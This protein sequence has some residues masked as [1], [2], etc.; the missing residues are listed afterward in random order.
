M[1]VRAKPLTIAQRRLR[2]TQLDRRLSKFA[3]APSPPQQGWVRAIRTALR[4]TS[5]QLAGRLQITQQSV[6]AL[7]Q[8]ESE[9]NITLN[10]LRKAADALQCRFVYGFIPMEGTLDE[11]R[12]KQARITAE[13]LV[14]RVESTMALENQARALEVRE[15]EVKEIA[16][17]LYRAFSRE[18]WIEP[19][20][21]LR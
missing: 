3:E 17:D 15:A 5:A 1:V 12:R 6:S 18:I 4:M 14:E 7:E 16:E 19:E 2:L 21:V 10:R 9:G 8:D 11:Y 13:R 20:N